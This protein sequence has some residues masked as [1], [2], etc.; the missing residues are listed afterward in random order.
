MLPHGESRSTVKTAIILHGKV[1]GREPFPSSSPVFLHCII[2]NTRDAQKQEAKFELPPD[3]SYHFLDPF[4]GR[5]L[6]YMLQKFHLDRNASG[7]LCKRRYPSGGFWFWSLVAY[8]LLETTPLVLSSMRACI[9]HELYLKPAPYTF[10]SYPSLRGSFILAGFEPQANMDSTSLY[11]TYLVDIDG[12]LWW[13]KS[14]VRTMAIILI[15]ASYISI[16][17]TD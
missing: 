3:A 7:K 2:C 4:S 17:R 1:Q 12:W 10:S 14:T 5:L 11:S 13:Y 6:M 8:I 9:I 15:P 16:A